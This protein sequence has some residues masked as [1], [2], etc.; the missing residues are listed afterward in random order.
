MRIINILMALTVCLS[1]HAALPDSLLT[2][3]KAYSYNYTSLDT[4][5]QIVHELR[6]QNKEPSWR[7]SLVEGDL[8]RN[9]CHYHAAID[10]L[11]QALDTKEV[12]NDIC[13][14]AEVW[15]VMMNCHDM[16]LDDLL[17]TDDLY[18][19]YQC[20][21]DC[22]NEAYQAIA[23]F[24]TGKRIHLHGDKDAG[25]R[26]C[27]DAFAKL[28]Q[29]DFSKK[30]FCLRMC[31]WV[32]VN[33]YRIDRRFDEA[34]AMSQ[35]QEKLVKKVDKDDV[36][37]ER[38]SFLRKLYGQRA[39]VLAED[40]RMKEADVAYRQW[41]N[42]KQGCVYDNHEILSYLL[43]SNRLEE[44]LAVIG[45]YKDYLKAEGDTVN[46]KMLDA[47]VYESQTYSMMNDYEHAIKNNGLMASIAYQLHQLTSRK[48]M[49]TRYQSLQKYDHLYRRNMWLL[50]IA[51]T[52]FGALVVLCVVVIYRHRSREQTA[53]IQRALNRASAYQKA[54]IRADE[55]LRRQ[56]QKSQSSSQDGSLLPPD[57]TMSLQ[58]K[59]E[60]DEDEMLFVELDKRITR[61]RLFL[62]PNFSRDDVIR[63][64][65]IDKNRIGRMMSRYSDATNIATYINQKRA[66][67]AANYMKKH[68]EY[69]VVA[70]AE[71]CGMT[72]TVTFNRTFK[73]LFSLTPSEYRQQVLQG[74][75]PEDLMT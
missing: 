51:L 16:L 67:Y 27:L 2:I 9:T 22:D 15:R 4:A 73:D 29:Y 31:S 41:L 30:L 43:L 42:E 75:L 8:Y 74:T 68:P 66:F 49:S 58:Q 40:N 20:A 50:G 61:D 60:A 65:G 62:D 59:D 28:K 6:G 12:K 64:L 5:L 69:T 55:E 11:Q 54:A 46:I 71:A 48:E 70:V 21:K 63:L 1:T 3:S 18:K 34:L 17:L 44:A 52:L 56:R 25:Y 7:L 13:L 35:Y 33:M 24:V 57:N 19:L 23:R 36:P 45:Y 37:G 38:S 10:C 26:Y 14:Q 53:R 72:N 47:L 32:L 39:S